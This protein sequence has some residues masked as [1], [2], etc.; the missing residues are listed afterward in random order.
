GV[1][2]GGD[3]R[4]GVRRH[5]ARDRPHAHRVRRED[6]GGGG[7]AAGG[8]RRG[9]RRGVQHPARG[10]HARQPAHAVALPASRTRHPGCGLMTDTGRVLERLHELRAGDAPT[11]GG[12]VLSY[13]YDSGRDELDE[14]ADAAARLARPLNGLDPTVF[15]SIAAMERDLIGFARRML[16]GGRGVV[17]S[18]TSGGTESCLLAVKTARDL[19]RQRNPDGGRPRLVAA[20]TAHAAFQKAAHL[21][22]LTWDPVPC[23]P[24]GAVR[25]ADLIARLDAEVAL[26][27]V[28]APAYPSGALD[29][30][31]AVAEAAADRG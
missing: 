18:V 2:G 6:G 27:I 19:W 21:F 31:A 8:G 3:D 22:D 26:V 16:H 23:G 13:V 29:P 17:G 12:R 28:S 30:V 24:D 5:G 1:D 10:D 9:D 15:P 20:S 11:H 25:A 7:R 14:L 4:D